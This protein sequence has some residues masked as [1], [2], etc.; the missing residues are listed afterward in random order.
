MIVYVAD[1]KALPETVEKLKELCDYI[2]IKRH[3]EYDFG[4]YKKAY[5]YLQKVNLLDKVDS[6]LF[7]NDSV[8]FVGNQDD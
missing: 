1:S 2:I 6:L 5:Q 7:C 4:S 3:K 8:D